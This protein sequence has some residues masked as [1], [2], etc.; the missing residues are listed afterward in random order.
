MKSLT[1][2][3]IGESILVSVDEI[4]EVVSELR[5]SKHVPLATFSKLLLDILIKEHI[6]IV[7]QG[8]FAYSTWAN[9]RA[10]YDLDFTL[11]GSDFQTIKNILIQNGFVYVDTYD[12]R[13][14]DI[15]KFKYENNEVDFLIYKNSEFNKNIFKRAISISFFGKN[16]KVMSKEDLVVTKLIANRGKDKQDVINLM[17][18]PDIDMEYLKSTLIDL[19]ILNRLPN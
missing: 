16:L 17:A 6:K 14:V 9:P 1:D 4:N 3:S 7:L 19:K 12:Y 2:L 5:G 8:G 11:V 10:T 18:L 15:Y 13:L